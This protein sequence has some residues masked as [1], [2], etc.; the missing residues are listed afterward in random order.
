MPGKKK[1]RIIREKVRWPQPNG[2][3]RTRRKPRKEQEK[4]PKRA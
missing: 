2:P 4:R 3:H 1:P